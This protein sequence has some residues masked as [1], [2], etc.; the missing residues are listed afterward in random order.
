MI[1]TR[2]GGQS[3]SGSSWASSAGT[4]KR[5]KQL[6]HRRAGAGA[7]EQLVVG[8]ISI[9]GASFGRPRPAP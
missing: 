3:G 8:G 1:F 5:R 6:A 7:G 2:T 4:Q 9:A